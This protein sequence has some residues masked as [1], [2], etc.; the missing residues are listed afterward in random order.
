M[1]KNSLVFFTQTYPFEYNDTFIENE[2]NYIAPFF[3]KVFIFY[4][5]KIEGVKNTPDNVKL[6]YIDSP[7]VQ[8]KKEA[9]KGNFLLF[10]YLILHELLFSRQKKIFIEKFKYNLH[11]ILNCI[12][13]SEQI[14]SKL[15][16][17]IFNNATFYSYWFFDWNFSLSILKK[18]KKIKNSVTRAHGYDLYEDNGKPNYLPCRKFCLAN[19]DKVFTISHV[20]ENYLKELYPKYKKKIY[21]SYLG[22]KYFGT[23]PVPTNSQLIHLV[24]CSNVNQ[25]KRLHLIVE[26]LKHF[27]S[28]VLWTHI[29][30]GILLDDMK[31]KTNDLPKNVITDFKGRMTQNQIFEFYSQTP[32]DVFINCSISEGI[33]VSIMEAIS[34]GIPVIATD[35][36]GTN[37]IVNEQT[38]ILIP[39]KFSPADVET[40]I[41][42]N[43][44]KW[45][46]SVYRENVGHFWKNNFFYE[47]NYSKFISN[48]MSN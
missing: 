31:N 5:S 14:K 7:D 8:S 18:Q 27:N 21:C 17:E 42:N 45:R 19:T 23:N 15:D 41:K 29:G 3:D 24:S 4:K 22:T 43:N 11:H 13:Y 6:I 25:V 16:N 47:S 30:D 35:V 36:G 1:K 37:E 48:L 32:I 10:L 26:I 12:Y 20:G 9:I 39:A 46:N 34:F 28:P 40:I 44:L 2:L 38:G 33:P